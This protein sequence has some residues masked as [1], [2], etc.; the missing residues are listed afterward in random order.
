[1]EDERKIKIPVLNIKMMSDEEWNELAIQNAI[2]NYTKEFG[3]YP[4]RSE[5]AC[6][7]QRERV[8]NILR[9]LGEVA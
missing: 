5:D 2:E 9:E 4:E 3:H 6:K 8:Q 1:M 7:W